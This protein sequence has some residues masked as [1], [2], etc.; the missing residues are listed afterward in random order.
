MIN[1]LERPAI[2]G[3]LFISPFLIGFFLLTLFPIFMSFYLSFTTIT[4]SGRRSGSGWSI[5]SGCSRRTRSSGIDAS[6]VL[7]CVHGR[8]VP[9]V[10]ALAIAMLVERR[11]SGAPG[12]TERCCTCLR[13]SA[14]ASASP[15]CGDSSSARRGDQHDPEVALDCPGTPGSAIRKGDLDA[16]S[17]VR[18]AVRFVDAHFSRRTQKYPER[19]TT[20]R[21]EWTGREASRC[22]R[23]S[24]SRCSRRSFCSMSSSSS[25]TV[26][27]IHAG[28]IIFGKAGRSAATSCTYSTCTG[29]FTFLRN[30]VRSGMAWVLLIIV[31]LLTALIFK[32]SEYWVH[33]ESRGEPP[34]G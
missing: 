6:H 24:R 23:K 27:G 18:L 19:L 30:G 28:I 8:A 14:A 3:Y 34:I 26:S 32:S 17:A 2:S 16:H 7:L 21:R 15:S 22:F 1:K 5:T 4:C 25:S 11:S 9:A 12:F 10:V 29:R 33:Y 31:G 13:S 20:R